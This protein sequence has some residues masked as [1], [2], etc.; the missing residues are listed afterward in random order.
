MTS[1]PKDLCVK[2]IN[3]QFFFT[4]N[5]CTYNEMSETRKERK[6]EAESLIDK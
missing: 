4:L 5:T 6:K 2:Q 1:A 3:V